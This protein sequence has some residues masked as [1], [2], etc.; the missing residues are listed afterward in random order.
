M[1][2]RILNHPYKGVIGLSY[3][4]M[5]FEGAL[6]VVLI[7]LMMTLAN[8]FDVTTAQTAQ[9]ISLKSLGTILTLYLAGNLS[10]KYGRKK[11]ML[12]GLF[13]FILFLIGFGFT[14]NFQLYYVF[15]LLAGIGHG[16]M[17][18]PGISLLFDAIKGNTG[19]AMSL[20]QVF[21]AAGSVLMTLLSSFFI[22][23]NL[24][25]QLI[26]KGYLVLAVILGIVIMVVK[27]PAIESKPEFKTTQNINSPL[28][29]MAL[30]LGT[31][32]LSASIQA[33]LQ[34]WIPTYGVIEKGLSEAASVSLLSSYQIGA[35]AG[36]FVLAF[37]LR[38]IHSTIFMIVN[39]II[40]LV[41]M[42]IHM[43]TSHPLLSAIT[44]FMM[45]FSQGVYFSLSINMGGELYPEKAGTATG[46][47]GTVNMIGNSL[48]VSISGYLQTTIGVFNVFLI[49]LVVLFLLSNSAI[50]F[51][52]SYLKYSKEE[53][54]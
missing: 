13:F 4:T 28:R 35:V 14:N 5:F 20:V 42:A 39:P 8:H 12:L 48:M 15:A 11:I 37:L 16:L 23:N 18:S 36:A 21:F 34:T 6:N 44:L 24:P 50:W 2:E 10:D 54:T 27:Y 51:R 25:W 7:T 38:K 43:F 22:A 3:L 41:F 1:G 49:G 19:P 9:L 17:D 40:V 53:V 46:L 33:I 26:F 31:V 45:G 29:V 52:R 30:L 47:V 32:I